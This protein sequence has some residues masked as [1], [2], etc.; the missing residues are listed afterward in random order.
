MAS[1]GS[2]GRSR[3]NRDRPRRV[4]IV[5]QN[6]PVPFDRRVWLEATTLAKAGYQV[7]VVSPKAKGYNASFEVIEDVHVHRYGLPVDAQGAAGFVAEFVWCFLRTAMKSLRVATRG[8]GFDVLHVCNPPETYWPLGRFW[9]LFGKRFLFDHHDL[10]PEMYQVKFGS[11][12]GPALAGLRFLER[13]TFAAADLVVTTNES[14]KR[15]A[16][17]RGGVAPEDVYVVR[18]GPDLGR[19]T[20]Y[21]P[22]DAWRRGKRHLI[23]YLGEICKQD[24]ADHLVRAVKLLRDELGRDDVHCVLV[25][26]GPHQPAV[27]AYAEEI[28]VAELCTFTGRVSDD[29]LCRI[30]SSADLG[31]DPDPKNDWSDYSTMNKIMEYMFFGLP[32]VAYD[33]TEARVSA[34]GAALF[35]EPN[36]ERALAAGIAELLDDEDRRREMGRGGRERVRKELAWEHSAPVLLAAYDRL[37][38]AP[39][40]A[41]DAELSEQRP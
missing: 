1:A 21:P 26:G 28:G 18:S 12:G 39:E 7:S 19:L 3:R 27:K 9:K 10:S 40:A 5:V 6:L 22:D 35:T 29:D 16:T 37:W 38:P 2:A 17:A 11:A 15:I 32:I 24:G 41:V 31:V 33:L 14:H 4:L 34:G 30:L 25:G 8:R 20:V 23:V 36:N 13:Q